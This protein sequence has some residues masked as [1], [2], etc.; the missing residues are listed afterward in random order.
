MVGGVEYTGKC[1][2]TVCQLQ[3]STVATSYVKQG[4]SVPSLATS[5]VKHGSHLL[6]APFLL[7]LRLLLSTVINQKNVKHHSVKKK[8]PPKMS[9]VA[10]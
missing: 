8:P 3:K 1:R 5:Y 7:L 4:S 10:R 2:L 6:R 9:K